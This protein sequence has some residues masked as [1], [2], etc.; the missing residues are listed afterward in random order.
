MQRFQSISVM[1]IKGCK[2]LTELHDMSGV[3]NL[4]ELCLDFCENLTKVHVS[5][6]F[7]HRLERLSI[8][9]CCNLKTF[10]SISLTSLEL[11]DL[12]WC[13]RLRRFP[14]ILR[15]MENIRDIR[16]DHSGIEEL[17]LSFRNLTGLQYLDLS[18]CEHLQEFKALPPNLQELEVEDR[19][20][21]SESC[22]ILLSQV[23]LSLL[24]Y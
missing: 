7:L 18:N 10:P 11:F 3:P 2:S 8:T 23:I 17:P 19:H 5:I 22:S 14:E 21:S 13:S 24:L 15:T 20:L 12:S 16:L 6:G 1:D 4:K 9:Y